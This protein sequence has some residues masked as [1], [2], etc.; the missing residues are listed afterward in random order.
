MD[1]ILIPVLI[2]RGFVLN[3]LAIFPFVWITIVLRD[4]VGLSTC[5]DGDAFVWTSCYGGTKIV[6]LNLLGLVATFPVGRRARALS[7]PL[8]PHVL[9]CCVA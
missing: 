3:L 4:K 7:L 5:A 8:L 1:Q 6:G 9:I 2:C